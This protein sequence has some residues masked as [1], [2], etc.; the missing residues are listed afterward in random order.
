M[1]LMWTDRCLLWKQDSEIESVL[2]RSMK[3]HEAM[4][5]CRYTY[6][7]IH[8]YM[9]IYNLYIPELSK[10]CLIQNGFPS[11]LTYWGKKLGCALTEMFVIDLKHKTVH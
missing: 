10:Y 4:V 2:K 11:P 3:I 7:H 5:G 9:Y 1:D 8:I 6:T